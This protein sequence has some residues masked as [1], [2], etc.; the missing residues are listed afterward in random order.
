[1][2]EAGW[3]F[4]FILPLL[5]FMER[6]SR[7]D[8]LS[9]GLVWLAVVFTWVSIVASGLGAEVEPEGGTV[10]EGG[11]PIG[12]WAEAVRA[13][14]ATSAQAKRKFFMGKKLERMVT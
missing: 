11:V 1:M 4:T 6:F 14:P 7:I 13:E 8:A 9:A 2:V 3:L 5:R 10:P 12:V